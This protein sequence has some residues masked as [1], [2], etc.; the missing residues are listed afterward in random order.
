[1]KP[2]FRG[3]NSP[4]EELKKAKKGFFILSFAPTCTL[5]AFHRQLDVLTDQLIDCVCY[6]LLT[7][8][9][10]LANGII[11]KQFWSRLDR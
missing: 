11:G 3:H 7:V 8:Q 9:D 6:V 2:V 5:P 4:E 1:M 10:V